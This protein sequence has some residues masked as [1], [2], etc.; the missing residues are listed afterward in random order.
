MVIMMKRIKKQK[1]LSRPFAV[2]AQPSCGMPHTFRDAPEGRL[3]VRQLAAAL[4]GLRRRQPQQCCVALARL[5]APN[6]QRD[7]GIGRLAGKSFAAS[8][9]GPGRPCHATKS[10]LP[11]RLYL[12]AMNYYI[13]SRIQKAQA[14]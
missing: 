7:C 12:D 8:R 14:A 3:G 13:V 1:H 6:A 5:V 9:S 10:S 11:F 2:E 4:Q